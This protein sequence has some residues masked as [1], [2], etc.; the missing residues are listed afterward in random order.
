[1]VMPSRRPLRSS[2][3]RSLAIPPTGDDA[4]DRALKQV[5]QAVQVLQTTASRWYGTADLATGLNK[6]RHGLGRAVRGFTITMTA[7]D[8]AFS[9]AINVSNP[10]PDL[11][12]WIDVVD[13]GIGQRAAR[14]E[15]W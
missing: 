2:S 8:A 14:L 6:I 9:S 15:V 3:T 7:T 12:V 1:M 13:S 4:T 11:E 10:R 5:E